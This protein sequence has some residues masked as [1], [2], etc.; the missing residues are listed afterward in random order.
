MILYISI[1][2]IYA[3]YIFY[4]I[5]Y[6]YYIINI[7]CENP[8]KLE[9]EKTARNYKEKEQFAIWNFVG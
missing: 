1:R 8:G 3:Q 2:I 7:E 6:H 5:A 9:G 4:Y